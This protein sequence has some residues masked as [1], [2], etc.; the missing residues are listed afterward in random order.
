MKALD[1]HLRC[2]YCHDQLHDG[3]SAHFECD[4]CLAVHH[5]DCYNA[6]QGC[7]IFQCAGGDY[8]SELAEHEMKIQELTDQPKDIFYNIALGLVTV[9]AGVFLFPI[10]LWLLVPVLFIALFVAIQAV[11]WSIPT[12]LGWL[13]GMGHSEDKTQSRKDVSGESVG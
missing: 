5:E 9:I 8:I 13:L 3:Y 6:F 11:I 7:S 2:P 4:V 10:A 1:S 12:V